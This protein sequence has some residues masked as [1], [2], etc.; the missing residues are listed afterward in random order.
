MAKREAPKTTTSFGPPH[1]A[2]G[3]LTD[4]IA[5]RTAQG[6][7]ARGKVP[8]GLP[9]YAAPVGG[10][11][12][13]PKPRLD[14]PAVEG[15]TMADQARAMRTPAAP[16]GPAVAAAAAAPSGFVNRNPVPADSS[17]R[18]PSAP[19]K[20]PQILPSD[21]LPEAARQ[22]PRFRDGQGAMYASSQPELAAQYGVIR[23]RQH[24]PPQQLVAGANPGSLSPATVE[25]IKAIND[26]NKKRETAE[27]TTRDSAE[28]ASAASS[29]GQAARLGQTTADEKPLTEEDKKRIEA[30]LKGMDD[31]DFHALRERMMKDILNNEQQKE[32]IEGRLLPM[33][34]S[35]Y[36][37]NG[38]VEQDVAINSKLEYTF[39]S[40]DGETDLALKRLVVGEAR[41]FALDD[42][43]ILDKYAIMA[44]ACSLSRINRMPLPDYRDEKGDFNDEKFWIKF[45]KVVKL[46]IHILASVGV[47][48][49]WFDIRV[50]KLLVAENLGNG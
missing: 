20:G 24:I 38:Y 45:N 41:G 11:Q 31:F 35:D 23:N 21:L 29:A 16:P 8:G 27:G 28:A 32:L 36:V 46:G 3:L 12:Q 37:A 47:N 5:L 34:L 49:F 22:D 7:A 15:S 6:M 26:F 14:F 42:R 19:A 33:D 13:P 39:R 17:F 9:G 25:G 30:A 43:Y 1:V 4:P 40:C 2:P 48:S 44:M 18:P 10:G 50:R